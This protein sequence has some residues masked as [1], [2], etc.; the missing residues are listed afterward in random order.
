VAQNGAIAGTG[1]VGNTTLSNARKAKQ[2]EFYTQLS[3]IS[4][5][6]RHYKDQLRGKTVFCNCDDPFESNFFKYFALNFKTLGLKKLIVTC[7]TKS[8]IAGD[9]LPL[10]DIQGLKPEG[11]EPYAIEINEVPDHNGDG[12]IDLS[13]VEYLLRHN[14][15]A[16]RTLK[17]DAT[18][19][20]GDFRSAECIEY[21]KQSDVVVT[22]PPFSLFR[23]FIAQIVE[24]NKKLLVIGSQSAITYREIFKLVKENK[25]WLGVNNGGTKWFRVPFDYD[26]QTESRKKI[27]GGIKYFSMGS[28]MWFTNLDNPRR[29]DKITLFKNYISD[30]YPTYDNYDAIEVGKVADIP[31]DYEG[32]MGVP[33]TFLDK[34]NP[35]QFEV[36]GLAAGNI[37][38][39]AGIPTKTGKDGPYMDGKLKYGRIL[40]RKIKT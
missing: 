5:E 11:K 14:A 30:E 20:A 31:I 12:A 35:E 33:I 26:I 6:L 15:N 24:H 38:G 7:Y 13:D 39:L 34:Y 32:V 22:N 4:N 18:Y 8:P 1:Q 16:S 40:I 2:D 3:D 27:E 25:L 21:L 37:R 9:H 23:E 36:I 19:G 10:L 28:V 17:G 29:H